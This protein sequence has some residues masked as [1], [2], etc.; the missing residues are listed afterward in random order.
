MERF[1]IYALQVSKE[2][3]RWGISLS[4]FFIC[5]TICKDENNQDYILPI[6]LRKK[7]VESLQRESKTH[8][9]K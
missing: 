7:E 3:G 1:L 9:R 8:N 2:L 4:A 5:N 6:S